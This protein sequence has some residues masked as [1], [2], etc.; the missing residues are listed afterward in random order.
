[1]H[2]CRRASANERARDA[3]ATL[4]LCLGLSLGCASAL[5]VERARDLFAREK[6]PETPV[7]SEAPPARIGAVEG[8]RTLS[9]ELR[10]IPLRWDPLL[11][12]DVGGYAV[13][14]STAADGPFQRIAV[15]MGRFQTAYDRPRRRPRRRS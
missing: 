6:A 10:A 2:R 14:R 9:G 1:M 8:L 7:L 15:V 5:D 3:R 13:E 4:A 12:G 11:A